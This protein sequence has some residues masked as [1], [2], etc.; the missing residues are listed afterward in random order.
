[1][2]PQRRDYARRIL[3]LFAEKFPYGDGVL[4]LNDGRVGRTLNT[5]CICDR[6]YYDRLGYLYRPASMGGYVS[7]YCDDE[8]QQVSERLGRAAYVD[9]VILFHNWIGETN[10]RDALHR[11]NEAH[12]AAD[13]RTFQRRKKA[14]FPK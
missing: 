6:K 2:V 11:R 5:L 8:W 12:Y 7:V 9:E 10:P 3:E 13:G 4:H 14:G 1:M